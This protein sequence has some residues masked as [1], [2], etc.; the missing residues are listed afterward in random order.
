MVGRRGMLG[1]ARELTHRFPCG[2]ITRISAK[3]GVSSYSNQHGR[4]RCPHIPRLG[5]YLLADEL[6]AD[7]FGL[8][9]RGVTIVGST[10][11][12]HFM[13]R[14][15]SEEAINAGLGEKAEEMSRAA[16][17]P[18]RFQRLRNQLPHRGHRDPP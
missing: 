16:F 8:I 14:T 4:L 18:G 2:R 6:T 7:P 5:S 17:Q 9:H 11:D 1:R 15:F 3:S 10:F 13:V 12:K